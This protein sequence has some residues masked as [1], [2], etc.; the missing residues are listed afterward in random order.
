LI[1]R[2]DH[3]SQRKIAPLKASADAIIIDSTGLSVEGVVEKIIQHISMKRG[4]DT[5]N[6]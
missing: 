5:P 6:H 4:G 3:D 1:A 2:D